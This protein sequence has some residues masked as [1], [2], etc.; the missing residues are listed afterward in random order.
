[1]NKRKPYLIAQICIIVTLTLTFLL[2]PLAYAA[3]YTITPSNMQGWAFLFDSGT[4]GTGQM[5]IG[6][7]TP[8]AGAG[9]A[10]LT[11]GDTA[12]GMI[13]G[14][15]G[16]YTGTL[17][18]NISALTYSTYRTSGGAAQAPSVQFAYDQDITDGITAWQGRLVYEPYLNGTP[19]TGSWQTWDALNGGT[20]LWWASNNGISTVD[21][22]C[23]MATPCTW[24]TIISTFPNIAIHPVIPQML[25]KAGSGWTSFDGNVDN[26]S[27]TISG[28]TDT[29]NFEPNLPVH[30][31]TQGTD[32]PTIQTAINTANP[33]DVI[34]VDPG[35]YTENVTI[36]KSLTLNG[37]G[38][39]NNPA[40][41]TI[42]EAGA[43]TGRGIFVNS[44]VTNVT[45]T[46]IRVQNF[47]NSA[48]SSGI[49]ANG[50]NNNFTIQNVDVY[51]N[52]VNGNA[53]GG[54]Y[55]NGPVD[56]V[57]IDNV[58]AQNNRTRGIVIWNGFKT[59]ITITNNTVRNNICC[60]IELQ[61]G[62]ASGVTMTGNT[63]INNGDNGIGLTGLRAGAGPNLIAN[64]TLQDN[65]RFGIEI[66]LP[67][68][69]GLDTG[70]G[71]IVVENN[72]VSRTFIPTDL[73]DLVGIA[74]FRR[75]W[76]AGNNNVDIPTGVVIRNNT[77]SGYQQTS[78][79]DGFGIVVEGT[80]MIVTGN[81]LNNNDVGVQNQAGHLPY[82]PFTNIDGDQSNLPDQYFG[83]GNSPVGCATITS[84]LF[85]GNTVDQ[86][87]VGPIGSGTV[88]NSNTGEAFCTI[89]AA[90][91]DT[92]TIAGHTISIPAGIFAENVIIT[93][94]VTIAGAGVNNTVL[95]PAVSNANPC[96]GSSMCGSPTA[97][98]N[99]L[100]VQAHN[101]I[102]RD[103]T[104][105]GDNPNLTSGIIRSGADLDARN[106]IIENFYAGVYNNLEVHDVRVLNIYLRG[107][108]A[109]TGG[110][111]FNLHD[112]YVENVNGD[113]GS[114]AIFNFGG[115]GIIANNVIS[116]TNDSV[117]ANW[118]R[119]TQML[120]N[121]VYNS[122]SGVHTDNNGGSGGVA[123]MLQGNTVQNCKAAG[124]GVWVFAPYRNVLVD[125]NTVNNCEVGLALAGSQ[126]AAV[127]PTFSNNMVMGS[128][129]ANT[130]GVYVTTSLFGFGSNN[131]DGFFTANNISSVDDGFYLEIDA[132]YTLNA[133]I[134]D[135]S[136][137]TNNTVFRTVDAGGTAHT[138]LVAGNNINNNGVIFT[139]NSGTLLAFANNIT[140]F[141]DAGLASATGTYN[142]GHNWWGDYA[143]PAPA[144]VDA[145]SWNYRLGSV[146]DAYADAT[147]GTVSLADS[148]MNGNATL[149]GAGRLVL[150][151]HGRAA[152]VA[153]APFGKAVPGEIGAN[154]CTDF[155]DAFTIGGSGVYD[156]SLPIDPGA[157][158]T[159]AAA[160]PSIQR[161]QVEGD[162]SPDATCTSSTPCWNNLLATW[163]GAN[164]ELDAVGVPIGFFIGT[165]FT[166]P[167][168]NSNNP[169]V[170]VMSALFAAATPSSWIILVAVASLLTIGTGWFLRRQR[171]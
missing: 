51:T 122:S 63:I 148:T 49:W 46:G 161:F 19:V 104:I 41:H 74:A 72:N 32:H 94:S 152:T 88:L 118:S 95:H 13:I 31:I 24:N 71:S 64:N 143:D 110:T 10:Q 85:V 50:N 154:Q 75:G 43:L 62:T 99:I 89:Q 25:F 151:S 44:N 69:T 5:V 14:T 67:D 48:N 30:N 92:N 77:V 162:G 40:V 127:R 139:H 90:I 141:T 93:K 68:G 47:D 22:T 36:D 37:A 146:V 103:L 164:S 136:M 166:A 21:N 96:P 12:T 9:S 124:Y 54:I 121:Q 66:K 70:D 131:V 38:A 91:N 155:Y 145:D 105:D 114:I 82:T 112:N 115:S 106:G 17:L 18:S 81:T 117:A 150:V 111:G 56:T 171:V 59:N 149:S 8:P 135:G 168:I 2:A 28:V 76:V 55:M 147:G 1:M 157:C 158:Q 102:I 133:E 65:G 3:A 142:A 163:D 23:P 33:A 60:G 134:R 16:Y 45:I 11:V 98:S 130:I 138:V 15:G 123:D 119:G 156:L 116:D 109:S 153:E 73:R 7:S 78:T 39:G 58:T 108:Y 129:A 26:L 86:R 87:T 57:L 101:V 160:H 29:Y 125:N 169:T 97:S 4:N 113:G 34:Q 137:S 35:T 52:G 159:V 53:A 61:D 170:I 165:P 140:A 79:S 27:I 20:G 144:G 120:N 42:L 80:N 6:P 107:I 100:V 167:S 128:G 132:A 84:N 126:A 83:R